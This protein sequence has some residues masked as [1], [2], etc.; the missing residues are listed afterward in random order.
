MSNGT[1]GVGGTQTVALSAK[2]NR[3]AQDG[4]DGDASAMQGSGDGS[5]RETPQTGTSGVG[6]Q[7]EAAGME[8][9]Q[10]VPNPA[11]GDAVIRYTL[12]TGGEVTLRLYDE[13]GGEVAVLDGGQRSSGEHVVRVDVSRLTSGVYHYRLEAGGRMITR[14]LQVV[15]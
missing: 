8:L 9:S 10:S 2:A 12:R 6:S 4:S 7:A 3:T 13:Q 1:N 5:D 11:S 14:S 15:R